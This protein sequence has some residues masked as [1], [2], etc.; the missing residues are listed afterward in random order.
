VEINLSPTLPSFMYTLDELEAAAAAI[1]N[2]LATAGARDIIV[3]VKDNN[4]LDVRFTDPGG[5][6]DALEAIRLP[7][8]FEIID[9][10]TAAQDQIDSMLQSRVRTTAG[11]RRAEA[12]TAIIAANN[13][14]WLMTATPTPI[15]GQSQTDSGT[16]FTSLLGND[17]IIGAQVDSIGGAWG[18][19]FYLTDAAR[20]SVDGWAER[21]ITRAGIVLDG[22]FLTEISLAQLVEDGTFFAYQ[23][24]APLRPEQARWLAIFLTEDPL[25]FHFAMNELRVF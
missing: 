21:G 17:A 20:A 13:P 22:V 25:P 24:A 16:P 18:A 2:R 19:T 14:D 3:T 5:L 6:A 10:S 1:N 9:I 11:L 8:Q 7:G 23:P 12:R 15:A 4:T